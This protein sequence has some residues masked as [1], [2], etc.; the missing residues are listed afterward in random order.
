M[1]F[2][3]KRVTHRRIVC[4]FKLVVCF[5]GLVAGLP[6]RASE[7]LAT[8]HFGRG[9]CVGAP[10][11]CSLEGGID[12][13][14]D[15]PRIE[16]PSGLAGLWQALLPPGFPEALWPAMEIEDLDQG[17]RYRISLGSEE[18][19]G[20]DWVDL[21]RRRQGIYEGIDGEV[22][23]EQTEEGIVRLSTKDGGSLSFRRAEGRNRLSCQSSPAPSGLHLV[24]ARTSERTSIPALLGHVGRG[25]AVLSNLAPR[26]SEP[27]PAPSWVFSGQW[28]A[29]GRELELFDASRGTAYR[30]SETGRSETI[31]R[32]RGSDEQAAPALTS[33]SHHAELVGPGAYRQ[34][35][36]TPEA[37]EL[38]PAWRP[39]EGFA[40]SIPVSRDWGLAIGDRQD[41]EGV[42][43]SGL[44]AIDP[45]DRAK[46]ERLLSLD[47]RAIEI[48]YYFLGNPYLAAVEGKAYWLRLQ[49]EPTLFEIGRA[50]EGGYRVR[51][52]ARGA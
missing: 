1:T 8:F 45:L 39:V 28:S 14:G 22:K 17:I 23:L 51:A 16:E 46:P 34:A 9:D 37:A 33:G 27:G 31:R 35:V 32:A 40:D 10:R 21:R 41:D 49:E 29:D 25:S 12:R 2:G 36:R 11:N 43:T 13:G 47:P 15:G 20:K 24:A 30:F 3:E 52:M 4:V 18:A 26:R 6:F 48:S 7:S 19:W 38:R 5:V 44:W 42:W 50:T